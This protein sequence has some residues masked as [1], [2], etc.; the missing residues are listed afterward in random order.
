MIN[1]TKNKI[2]ERILSYAKNSNARIVLPEND[3]RIYKA[4]KIYKGR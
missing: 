4:K 3:S 1:I 2:C